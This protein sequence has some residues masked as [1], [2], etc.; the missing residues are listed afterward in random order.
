M[1]KRHVLTAMF[2]VALALGLVFIGCGDKGSGDPTSPGG[3]DPTYSISLSQTGT[4]TFPAAAPGY[5]TQ[6]ALSVIITN[7]GDQATGALTAVLSGANSGSFTLS[8]AGI[9]SI[10]VSGTGSFTVVP[11]TGLEAGTYTATVTVSG[12]NGI[13]ASFVVSFAVTLDPFY[14]INLNVTGTHTFTA[15][16]VGYGAQ[17]AKSV[18]ITNTGNQATGALTAALSGANSGSF[19]LSTAAISSI[20]VSG[21][22]SFT[23]V[24]NT[25]LE[26]GTYTATVTVSDGNGITAS[27]DVSFA[28]TLDPVYGIN[29]DI[30]GTHTFTAATVGYG[31]QTEKSVTIT[32][33]GNQTTGA[34]TAVLSGTNSASFTL[35]TA[36]ISSIAVGGAD[37]F[38]VVPKT[39][40]AAGTYIAIVTVSGGNGMTASFNI[41]FT[42]NPVGTAKVIYAWVD[43]HEIVTSDTTATLSRGG[44]NN[45]LIITVTGSGY[46]NYQ[47]SLNGGD[48]AGTAGTTS[49]TFSSAGHG[50]GKYTIGL[51]LKKDNAWYSTQITITVTN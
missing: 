21:T 26:A 31:A 8:T 20:A 22:G 36:G 43:E 5:G 10:A 4:H 11:N 45:S 41:S 30:I 15:A 1:R 25:G 42:V 6:T 38:T 35:S 17:T 47:W 28:V 3:T 32:N 2:S 14:G 19:T 51:R 44:A 16:T 12:G 24:P 37:S 9:S 18:T 23:V 27:F 50:N 7:T 46:S 13:T 34:L 33:T 40:L 39:G 48:I 49:Y 29:L